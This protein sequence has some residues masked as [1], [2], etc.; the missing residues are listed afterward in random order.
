MKINKNRYKFGYRTTICEV[1]TDSFTCFYIERMEN[2]TYKAL[3]HMS[4]CGTDTLKSGTLA[5]CYQTLLQYI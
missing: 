1:R 4:G 2:M 3:C 5:Q